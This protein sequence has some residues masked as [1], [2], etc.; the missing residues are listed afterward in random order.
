[1]HMGYWCYRVTA[2]MTGQQA[3]NL[4]KEMRR[5]ST[6]VPDTEYR[7]T[8]HLLQRSAD[9]SLS[10]AIWV[11]LLDDPEADWGHPSGVS[12]VHRT[13][14]SDTML[15]EQ[16]GEEYWEKLER[17]GREST[18]QS[19]S[20]MRTHLDAACETP[21]KVRDPETAIHVSSPTIC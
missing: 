7:I 2:S 11:D 8:T 18:V 6:P 14:A 3:E 9:P 12:L 1:M 5:Q 17:K 13:P 20:S 15:L 19:R 4:Q 10:Q 16:I 21:L